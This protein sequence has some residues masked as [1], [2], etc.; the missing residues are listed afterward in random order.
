M[1]A[2]LLANLQGFFE[3]LSFFDVVDILLVA[4]LLY[5]VLSLVKGTRAMQMGVGLALLFVVYQVARRFGLITLWSILD[6]ALTYIVLI[7]VVLF[8]NDIR[9]ALMRVGRRPLLKSGRSARDTHVFEEVIKAT[10]ALAQ[11]RIGALVVFERDA[12][13][14]EFIEPGVEL[15]SAVTKELLYSVFIP[16]FENPMHDGA[17]IIREGRIWQAGAFLPL[18]ASPKLDRALGTRHRAAIGISEETDAVV[19]IVSEERGAI[20]ICFNGNIIRD[21][22]PTTLRE[23]LFGLFYRSPTR[24]GTAED[25]ATDAGEPKRDG[26]SDDES[27]SGSDDSDER[28]VPSTASSGGVTAVASVSAATVGPVV[29]RAATGVEKIEETPT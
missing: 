29:A 22:E 2:D 9:R 21:L 8:Q 15:D 14:D 16:S 5:R 17:V 11:K 26:E 25:R 18:T 7:I 4:F 1:I 27:P 23:A 3:R 28:P 24:R 13:L 10:N 6:A 12:M 20:S 19:V